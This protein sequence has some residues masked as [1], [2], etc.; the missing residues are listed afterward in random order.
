MVNNFISSVW[1]GFKIEIGKVYS[2][3]FVNVFKPVNEAETKK[4]RVFDFDDTLVKT[5]S[6]IYVE[7]MQCMSQR[8]MINLIFPILK[9]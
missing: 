2:N 3:P 9:K 4:L 7:N 1:N 5:K 6:H 8:V